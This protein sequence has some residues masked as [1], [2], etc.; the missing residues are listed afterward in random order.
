MVSPGITGEYAPCFVAWELEQKAAHPDP[1]ESLCI[2]RLSFNEAVEAALYG[3]I[4]DAVSIATLLTVQSRAARK[5]LP[6][7]LMR[8]LPL[9]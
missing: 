4:Q 2:R 6:E 5:D 9:S 1:Q 3:T 7:S 8:L